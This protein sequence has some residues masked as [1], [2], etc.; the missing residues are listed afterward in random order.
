MV[1][2]YRKIAM[3]IKASDLYREILAF[4]LDG[5]PILLPSHSGISDLKL[6]LM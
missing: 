3:L 6:K 2:P 5:Q 4:G 1:E